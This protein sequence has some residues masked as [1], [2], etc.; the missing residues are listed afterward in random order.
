MSTV[1]QAPTLF[2]RGY[3]T[4]IT[5]FGWADSGYSI[6]LQ[7]DLKILVAGDSYA[8][9]KSDFVLARYNPDGSPDL[10][11]AGDGTLMTDL[12][13][14][15]YCQSLAIQSDGR[16]LL[17]GSMPGNGVYDFALVR[18]DSDG[19]LDT[20]FD[21]DGKV[22]TGESGVSLEGRSV[23]VQDDGMILLAGVSLGGLNRN[24]A[25]ARYKTDGSLDATFS[26]DGK[27][28]TDFSGGIDEGNCVIVQSDRKILLAGY[29]SGAFALARYNTDGTLDASFSDDGK[30]TTDFATGINSW[31]SAESV[32]LQ[33][34]KKILVA[35]MIWNAD[36]GRYDFALVRYNSDGI[37]DT[38]FDGDGIV[39]TGLSEHDKGYSVVVQSDGRIL[40][41]GSAQ[42]GVLWGIAVVR[43]K[44]DGTL[45]TSFDG[46]GKVTTTINDDRW[47][48]CYGT[49]MTVQPDG[50]ILVSG[51]ADRKDNALTGD[52]TRDFAVVRYNTNGS[53]DT[54]FGTISS[55]DGRVVYTKYG[56][57]V[58]LDSNVQIYDADL[59]MA[60]KYSGATLTLSRHGGANSGDVFSAKFSGAFVG[61]KE[62]SNLVT[63]FM[64]IG[65]INTN[66]QGLLKITFNDNATQ[67]VVNS[68]LQQIAYSNDFEASTAAVQIDWTF[69][70]G[71]TGNQGAGG[72]LSTTGSTFTKFNNAPTGTVIITGS[73]VQGQV[74]TASH[75]LKDLEGFWTSPNYVWQADGVAIIGGNNATISLTQNEVGKH[76]TVEAS[77]VDGLFNNEI[78]SSLQT[79]P[80]YSEG[81][82]SPTVLTISPAEGAQGVIA[83]DNIELTF[84]VPVKA[85]AGSIV[86]HSGSATGTVVAS[87]DVAT[88]PNLTI[89][90]NTLT[91]NPTTDLV[92]STHYYVTLNAGSINDFAGHPVAASTYNFTTDGAVVE[93]KSLFTDDF[94]TALNAEK[95]DYNHWVDVSTG[96]L[97]PSFY[98]RTQ[99]RQE[100]PNVSN[101][102]LHLKLDT[103]NPTY[104][105]ADPKQVPSFFGSEAITQQTFSNDAGG[106]V[107]EIKAH[108]VNPVDGIV[109][110][111]FSYIN[112]SGSLHDEI[113]FEAVS[114]T[115]DQIQTNIYANEPR[116]AGHPQFNPI[117][118]VL[119]EEHLYRIEW[120]QNAIRWLVDG[121][122]V[123][124]E[125]EN[126]PL[127]P[128]ALHLNIWVPAADWPEAFSSALNPVKTAA[129]NIA[130]FF[131]IDSVRV[132]QLS[133]TVVDITPPEV[134]TFS[135]ADAAT[136]VTAGSNIVLTFNEAIQKGTGMIEIHSASATG[137]VAASYDVATSSNLVVAG[138]TLTI[139]PSTALAY[140]T[141]HFVTIG[142]DNVKDLAG[143]N[144]AGTSTY[145]FTTQDSHTLTGG[146]TFWKTGA[147]I[148]GV[149]SILTSVPAA[150]GTQPV[151]FRNIQ[152]AADGSRTVEIWETSPKSDIGGVNLEFSFSSGSLAT[153]QSS[154]S[155]PSGWALSGHTDKSGNFILGGTGTPLSAGSV[156]LGT[157]TL[158]V[159]V[160]PQHFELLLKGEL[161]NDTIPTLGIASDSVA[162][163][164]DGLY[165]HFDIFDGTDI[166]TSIKVIDTADTA[167]ERAVDLLDAIT[168]LKSI[169]GLTP[170][171]HYQEIAGDF[172]KSGGVDLNDA[173]GILK[174][175]VDLPA[176]KPEWVFVDQR[177]DPVAP[178]FVD[179]PADTT[180]DLVG[181]LRGDV[182]GSYHPLAGIN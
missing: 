123:R 15:D 20:S 94:N 39:T 63:N 119:T 122:L 42:W 103:F 100:L 68:V 67:S 62:G 8:G 69:S 90:G 125:T 52:N 179:V 16:I 74:L 51:F 87:Y 72:A 130:C 111:M 158:T 156:K 182:D 58:V 106:I 93:V 26:G 83:S 41:A 76:I 162:T 173:I 73:A 66:S 178:I 115:L 170:L 161:G 120:F 12:G 28:T 176:S 75:T 112:N 134:T 49:D 131:D 177:V 29:S 141:H 138:N 126:I 25:L 144:S 6:G 150:T 174:H 86:L 121:E 44:S 104:N 95:W 9:S 88:S 98:G 159:P 167:T 13:G 165:Q 57:P 2:I 157:L 11:F 118:G 43:Y 84:N 102:E 117:S 30:L 47:T 127:Q 78:V 65:I 172:N 133:S 85:G 24:F 1:N 147:P 18:Y 96:A 82:L 80:V 35:G 7:G 148:A 61:L 160:N 143:N 107:F 17:A 99:Q 155:L 64:S 53:L 55:L 4:S 34:D 22:T 163:G 164:A 153:W 180:V 152:V 175:V 132:A 91:I 56:I 45:D 116:G 149:T 97:D 81:A 3:G 135:P 108:F 48:S 92:G 168:I 23:V 114:N 140:G 181:I 137:T 145:D 154:A 19:S 71:N 21:G 36:L 89:S 129:A 151:E 46:D 128:M 27:L 136:G 166:M 70:D 32:I 77:Y 79:V 110:G 50:K 139:N 169:V 31:C 40:V 146:V 37:L 113:D 124:V 101:G 59:A 105:P 14:M 109:G 60:G 10:S 5:D 171:N 142:D 33:P 38:S 54:D